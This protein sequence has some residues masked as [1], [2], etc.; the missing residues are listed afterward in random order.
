MTPQAVQ[1]EPVSVP[2]G[3]FL[4]SVF[5]DVRAKSPLRILLVEDE[6][7]DAELTDIALDATGVPYMLHRL[8][9]GSDVLPYISRQM[10]FDRE[11]WPDLILLDLG[12]PG[13]DGFEVLAEFATLPAV[14]RSIPIMILTGYSHFAYLRESY[15]LWIPAYVTKPCSPESFREVLQRVQRSR[16]F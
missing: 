6:A 11:L 10:P 12:L 7:S 5:A 13:K 2:S 9:K 14:I 3:V 16:N 1:A 8:E 15:G 4:P